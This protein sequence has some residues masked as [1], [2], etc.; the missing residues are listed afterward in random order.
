MVSNPATPLSYLDYV[1]D[2]FN[3]IL[4]MSVN[5][6]LAVLHPTNSW[7]S[8]AKCSV[9]LMNLILGSTLEVDGGAENPNKHWRNC[10][11]RRRYVVTSSAIFDQPDY[12]K[13]L[14]KCAMNWQR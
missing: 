9:A 2:S 10:R 13:S 4:L 6:A 12:K 3:V 1:M 14:M 11:G 5:P 7:I 8:C